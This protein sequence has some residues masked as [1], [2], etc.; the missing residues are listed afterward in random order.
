MDEFLMGVMHKKG[1][2]EIIMME[3]QLNQVISEG[4]E[5]ECV[6]ASRLV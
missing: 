6:Q 2:V 4:I 3:Q 5:L 1:C